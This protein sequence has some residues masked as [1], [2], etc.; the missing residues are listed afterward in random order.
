MAYSGNGSSTG[1]NGTSHRAP[2]P[3]GWYPDPAGYGQRYWDGSYWSNKANSAAP[4]A[5][6]ALSAKHR[7]WVIG[8]VIAVVSAIAVAVGISMVLDARP[9]RSV[10]SDDPAVE[11]FY[12]DLDAAG[13][14]EMRVG[15]AIDRAKT[16]C[17][18]DGLVLW[19]K[20]NYSMADSFQFSATAMQACKS[21]QK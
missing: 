14:G 9:V 15:D 2:A 3:A 16:A 10:H 20:A 1:K 11:A 7:R 12:R 18:G 17:D 19:G 21:L 5:E 13:F 8:G 6:I 4:K